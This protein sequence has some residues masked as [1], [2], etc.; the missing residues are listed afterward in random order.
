MKN[1][2]YF[3]FFCS[4][5]VKAQDKLSDIQFSSTPAA[6]IIGTQNKELNTVHSYEVLYSELVTPV[7]S[8]E[9]NIPVNLNLEFAPF[10]LSSNDITVDELNKFENIYKRIKI[11]VA[12]TKVD[13]D[14]ENSFSRAGI[15]LRLNLLPPKYAKLNGIG[16]IV[17]VIERLN[18]V[19]DLPDSILFPNGTLDFDI[20]LKDIN[21]GK[22]REKV[23]STYN[24]I[25]TDKVADR[26]TLREKLEEEKEKF[27]FETNEKGFSLDFAASIALDFPD[28]SIDY[29]RIDRWG[30]WL[31]ATY[32]E[33]HIA[34]AGIGRLSNYSFDPN[35]V[36]DNSMFFD[37]GINVSADFDKC[38]LSWEY[39]GKTAMSDVELI[40]TDSKFKEVT[41]HKWDASISYQITDN[42]LISLSYSEAK[43]NSDYFKE[44]MNQLLIGISAAIFN[45]K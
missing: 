1:I 20:L 8:T 31:N 14:S 19:A 29:S 39:I 40:N 23:T 22:I 9:N 44:K 27:T 6:T 7:L 35:T 2:F 33:G 11:S 32:K 41:E 10:F 45:F 38:K 13:V 16:D 17:A 4:I 5:I 12:S 26:Q 28:N 42:Y 18:V 3:L 43:G 37:L 36:F 25:R 24:S 30:A 34:V 21:D 15:G